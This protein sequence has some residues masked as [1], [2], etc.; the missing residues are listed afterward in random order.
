MFKIH[1]TFDKSITTADRVRGQ[2]MNQLKKLQATPTLKHHFHHY[3]AMSAASK[4]KSKSGTVYYSDSFDVET[5]S[6]AS[7]CPK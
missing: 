3:T 5:D 2:I 6:I 1:K 4:R 7:A